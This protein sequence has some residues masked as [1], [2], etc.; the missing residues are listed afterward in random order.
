MRVDSVQ[1]PNDIELMIPSGVQSA[2]FNS[3]NCDGY[4][5][6][7]SVIFVATITVQSGT[8]PTLDIKIQDSIDSGA[9]WQDTGIA[10]TQMNTVLGNFSVRTTTP[11]APMIRAVCTLGGAVPSYNFSLRA[12]GKAKKTIPS[13]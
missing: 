7:D 4:V 9:T 5:N 3:R 10:F 8:T 2:T 13:S 6:C 12:Y 11:L 1:V